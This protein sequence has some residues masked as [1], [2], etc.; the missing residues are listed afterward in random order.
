MDSLA[1]TFHTDFIA[2][3]KMFWLVKF[4]RYQIPHF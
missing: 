4:E 3:T 1:H 2:L